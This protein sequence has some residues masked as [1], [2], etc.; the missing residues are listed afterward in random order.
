M[1]TYIEY[2]QRE[3]L[4]KASNGDVVVEVVARPVEGGYHWRVEHVTLM[5]VDNGLDSIALLIR[6]NGEDYVIVRQDDPSADTPYWYDTTVFLL[7]GDYLVAQFRGS[8]TGD[9]LRL[10]YT[11]ALLRLIER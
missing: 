11:G 1:P 10:Y 8:T 5:D 7:E 9:R 3:V 2:R 4:D 6:G